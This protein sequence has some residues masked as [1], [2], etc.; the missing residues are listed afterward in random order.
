MAVGDDQVPIGPGARVDDAGW[1]GIERGNEI[2]VGDVAT[3]DDHVLG[4]RAGHGVSEEADW[5]AERLFGRFE[6]DDPA[7]DGEQFIG[8]GEGDH[9]VAS[10]LGG[11]R[12]SVGR[13]TRRKLI[14]T[15]TVMPPPKLQDLNLSNAIAAKQATRPSNAIIITH[16][17]RK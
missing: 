2:Q 1:G 17:G 10:E 6:P 3:D 8:G 16:F 11:L 12:G 13:S 15:L 14:T 4:G 5:V 9:G 7:R